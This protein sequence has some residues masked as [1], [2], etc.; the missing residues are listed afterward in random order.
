MDKTLIPSI[1]SA[2]VA[3]GAAVIAIW[4][5]VRVKKV[6]LDLAF[7]KAEADRRAETEKT[8]RRF[9]EPL[10]RAAYDLQSRIFN[11]V[12]VGFLDLYLQK[13]DKRTRS[14]ATKNT[15]FVIAQYFAW[16]ELVRREIQFIDLGADEQ[17]RKLT[18][19]QDNIYAIWQTTEYDPLLRIFA[20]EQRAIGERLIREGPRG[21]ECMGYASF[22]DFCKEHPD[23]LLCALEAEI[24]ALGPSL[25]RAIP[26]LVALQHSLL[27]LLAFLDPAEVRFPKRRRMKLDVSVS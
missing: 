15:L 5:Q 16:A 17:T 24:T 21:P 8:A 14:Y 23:P 3:V 12:K 27:E 26:R 10:G 2:V 25:E 18:E 20:G 6:E 4:G 13:G 22:L 1:I 9:R 11:I 19:L 7:Q